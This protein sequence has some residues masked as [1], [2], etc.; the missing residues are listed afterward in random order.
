MDY[1]LKF[2]CDEDVFSFLGNKI[3]HGKVTSVK[4][5]HDE[6]I[7]IEAFIES[8]VNNQAFGWTPMIDLKQTKEDA[9]QVYINKINKVES[10]ESELDYVK[11]SF[12]DAENAEN[13]IHTK[14][15]I[16]DK[17]FELSSNGQI[18]S[19]EIEEIVILQDMDNYSNI[20]VTI[21]YGIKN[22]LVM[23]LENVLFK[24]FDDAKEC[25]IQKLRDTPVNEKIKIG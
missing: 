2:G 11:D 25:F 16:G 9:I 20:S 3:M 4:I 8:I 17:V 1:K 13:I 24:S 7:T 10:S 23:K 18:F 14:Y 6:E 21:T 15:K 12:K 19:Y 22:N 5:T